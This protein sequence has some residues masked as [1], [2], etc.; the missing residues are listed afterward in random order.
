MGASIPEP[1]L[2]CQAYNEAPLRIAVYT[3]VIGKYDRVHRVPEQFTDEAEFYIFSDVDYSH[4]GYTWRKAGMT[5][6][7]ARRESRLYKISPHKYLPEYDYTIYID[8]SIKLLRSPE[9]L[10]RRY[11]TGADIALHNHPWR[12]CIYKEAKVCIDN[13][14]VGRVK[15]LEQIEYMKK[16][17]YPENEGLFENGVIIRANSE[18]MRRLSDDWQEIYDKFTARDQLSLAYVMWKHRINCNLIKNC[19]RGEST[20]FQYTGHL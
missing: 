8:G 1:S 17:G 4:L 14:I 18:K 3:S 6:R 12:D 19:L 2:C 20:E 5:E 7:T 10:V 11:L 9:Y 16:D 13:E 15:G